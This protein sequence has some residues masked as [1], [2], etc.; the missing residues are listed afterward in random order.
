MIGHSYF[1][2][3]SKDILKMKLEYEIIPLLREYEKDGIITL[4]RDDRKSLGA[5]WSNL[6]GTTV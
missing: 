1:M 2:A 4:S 6:F 5:E 3:N